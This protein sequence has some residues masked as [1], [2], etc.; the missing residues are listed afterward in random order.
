MGLRFARIGVLGV[1]ATVLIVMSPMGAIPAGAHDDTD[2]RTTVLLFE[3]TAL[4]AD[5][6]PPGWPLATSPWPPNGARPG[7]AGLAAT[8]RLEIRV[9]GGQTRLRFVV[10]G[11]RG[12]TLYTI[13]TVFKPLLWCDDS[14]SGCPEAFTP[15][16]RV[17]PGFVDFAP[18]ALRF[19]PEAGLVAPTSSMSKAFTNG[20][21]L[22]P[23]ATFFTDQDGNGELDIR[24]DYNLLGT[25]YDDGPP[26]G[27]ADTV[28]QCTVPGPPLTFTSATAGPTACPPVTIMVNGNPVTITPRFTVTSSWL[29]KY[30]VQAN[31]PAAE[32]ANYAPADPMS[33]FWQCIDPAT[34]DPQAG[35]GLPRVWRY[36]FDHFRLA[37]H[38]DLLT[39]GF[40]GG[41]AYEHAIDMVGR[42]CRLQPTPPGETPCL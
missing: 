24:L 6:P 39:H 14:S 12:R 36:P 26:V 29:R 38:P 28:A 34:F 2:G 3:A 37:A 7:V 32:C 20:M 15:P 41:S 27:N 18:G 21:G 35:T 40:I 4:L 30:I 33:L 11:A 25:T 23:G 9:A 10:R 5:T 16:G 1:V 42:R 31:D 17:V 8:G 19:Y 13:W 22:D